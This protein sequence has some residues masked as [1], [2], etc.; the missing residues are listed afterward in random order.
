MN[1]IVFIIFLLLRIGCV[2]VSHEKVQERN[3]C[4]GV[5]R[6]RWQRGAKLYRIKLSDDETDKE[7]KCHERIKGTNGPS[8][9]D[10]YSFRPK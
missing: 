6:K 1:I 3:N 9:M 10:T 5:M 7:L 4:G 8:V 2:K